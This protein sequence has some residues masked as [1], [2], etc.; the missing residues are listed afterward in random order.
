MNNNTWTHR[1]TEDWHKSRR[2][3]YVGRLGVIVMLPAKLIQYLNQCNIMRYLPCKNIIYFL[4]LTSLPQKSRVVCQVF[5]SHPPVH[6]HKEK[7][8]RVIQHFAGTL[9]L[10]FFTNSSEQTFHCAI[11]S[12]SLQHSKNMCPGI[13]NS[14]SLLGFVCPVSVEHEKLDFEEQYYISNIRVHQR[15]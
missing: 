10:I 7:Q 5:P 2:H 1:L 15:S 14:W 8:P 11:C 9:H 3:A 12:H 6:T 4:S 13:R